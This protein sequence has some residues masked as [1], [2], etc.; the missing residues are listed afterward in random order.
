MIPVE[1]GEPTLKRRLEDLD[2]NNGNLRANLDLLEEHRDKAHI[3]EEAC[4]QRAAR[5]YN[6]CVKPRSFQEGDLV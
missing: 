1:V 4:K 3:R 5:R 6:T 2:I